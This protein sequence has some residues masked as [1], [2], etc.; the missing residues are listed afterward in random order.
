MSAIPTRLQTPRA[1]ANLCLTLEYPHD[2]II[3]GLRQTFGMTTEEATEL[4]EELAE[5]SHN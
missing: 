2:E 3:D 1:L 4:V 5:T